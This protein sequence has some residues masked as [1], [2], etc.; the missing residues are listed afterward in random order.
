MT[1]LCILK[2]SV[3]GLIPNQSSLL[4]IIS[5]EVCIIHRTEAVEYQLD[6]STN[7]EDVIHFQYSNM[8]LTS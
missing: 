7:S 1:S 8:N 2:S 3:N 6:E 5:L 4:T